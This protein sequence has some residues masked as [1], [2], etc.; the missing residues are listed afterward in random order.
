MIQK[1][2]KMYIRENSMEKHAHHMSGNHTPRRIKFVL[3]VL[4]FASIVLAFLTLSTIHGYLT[5]SPGSFLSSPYLI[6]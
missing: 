6:T 1:H 3:F 2:I 5:K 4:T